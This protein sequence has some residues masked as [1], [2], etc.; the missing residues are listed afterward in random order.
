VVVNG[1]F[2]DRRLNRL[3]EVPPIEVA[4]IDRPTLPPFGAGEAATAPV[5]ASLGNAIFDATV[6]GC[7]Q[8]RSRQL[9]FGAH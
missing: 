4:L 6:S 1:R 5:A 8:F 9:A 3:P 2:L 7:T